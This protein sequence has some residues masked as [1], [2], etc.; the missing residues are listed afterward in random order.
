MH[1]SCQNELNLVL[2]YRKVVKKRVPFAAEIISNVAKQMYEREV[3]DTFQNVQLI[4][5]S[6][7]CHVAGFVSRNIK[8]KLK[9]DIPR[10]F[11][12]LSHLTMSA[13]NRR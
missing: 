7:G 9:T 2:D 10:I 11:G 8:E 4:G 13:L 5:F 1:T 12:K 6:L 3:F